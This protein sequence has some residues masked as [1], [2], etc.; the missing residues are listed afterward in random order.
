MKSKDRSAEIILIACTF[1][2]TVTVILVSHFDS[3]IYNDNTPTQSFILTENVSQTKP[4]GITSDGKIDLNNA[5]LEEL[6][7]LYEIGKAKAQRI[8]DFRVN[9]GGFIYP[10]ELTNIEGITP[11]I[12]EKNKNKITVGEYIYGSDR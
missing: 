8:I 2:I 7:E 6:T 9:N 11:K 1:I 3:P 5:T 10:E 12:Y 4:S